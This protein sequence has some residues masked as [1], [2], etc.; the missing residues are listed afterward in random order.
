MKIAII[1]DIFGEENN[2][3]V[4]TTVNLINSLREKGHEVRVLC[5]A[6]SYKNIKDYY[7]CPTVNFYCFNNYV[8]KNGVTVA[9]TD[10]KILK[11]CID[12]VD[13]VHIMIPFGLGCA[14]A[15]YAEKNNIPLT[16]GY[17]IQ[18]E[19]LLS[20]FFLMWCEPA[21]KAVYNVFWNKVYS[22]TDCIHFPTQ[23]MKTT[24]ERAV[25]PTNGYVISN[26]VKPLFKREHV[27]KP[28]YLKDKFVIL[29]TGRYSKEKAQQTLLKAVSKSK[30]ND[31]IQI[32]LAGDGPLKKKFEKLSKDLINKPIFGLHTSEELANIINYSDLYVHTAY[33]DLESIACLEALQCGL[34]PVINDSKQSAPRYFALD[35]NCL[36]KCN[37]ANSL[38]EKIE[39]W[40]EHAEE[41][42]ALKQKYVDF[43]KKFDFETCMNRM[44]KMLKEAIKIRE[45]KVKNKLKRRVI[46]YKDPL[47]ENFSPESSS[48]D[49]KAKDDYIYVSKNP[50]K[51]VV[52]WIVYWIFAK[53]V[54]FLLCN[55]TR[56]V[57]VRNR[58][59]IKKLRNKGYF[60]YSNHTNHYDAFLP[61]VMVNRSKKTYIV[62]DESILSI[63][64]LR[65]LTK[66]LGGLPLPSSKRAEKNFNEALKHRFNQKRAIALY[67]EG[68]IWPFANEIRPFSSKPFIY[69]AKFG[70]PVVG[71]LVSYRSP[72]GL[73]KKMK[74]PCIDITLSQPIYPK[75]ELSIEENSI[76]LRD[77]VYE[78]MKRI[79]DI[80]IKLDY[81][82]Y[83]EAPTDS[84]KYN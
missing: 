48:Y 36:Y 38:K 29:M 14:A 1:A 23:F 30:Y 67:P 72:R 8:A 58:K 15:K 41:K 4:I 16:A 60:I 9:K 73:F 2:G 40:I 42:E 7:I 52:S 56:R 50:I 10:M 18:A 5:A 51:Q 83:A 3:T 63:P 68:T 76:Y 24:Y 17:H 53:P 33:A 65:R 32:I 66:I 80:G 61:H 78:F 62:A 79:S 44:E 71:M 6:V 81:I 69:P 37:N 35:K 28:E 34:V 19:N 21:K 49:G 82:N 59:E 54:L 22:K 45:Y 77:Q 13:V 64:G 57:K 75:K 84:P 47:N 46:L 26:G 27:N 39:Y 43:V 11:E 31:K 12:G 70:A 74:K 55:L 20:H 25:G